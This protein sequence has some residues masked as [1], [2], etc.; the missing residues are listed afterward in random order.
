MLSSE[1][2][3]KIIWDIL[4]EEF[5]FIEWIGAVLGFTIGLVQ[6]LIALIFF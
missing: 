1:K 6:V 2:L 4:A 5:K 3:E